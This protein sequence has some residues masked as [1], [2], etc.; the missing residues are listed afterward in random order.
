MVKTPETAPILLKIEV[1]PLVGSVKLIT[2]CNQAGIAYFILGMDSGANSSI[3]P[4]SELNITIDSI[5]NLS[6]NSPKTF[7]P[8]WKIK[9]YITVLSPNLEY[10][11]NVNP[12][13]AS[14]NYRFFYFNSYLKYF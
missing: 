14:S 1:R 5:K 8:F 9:G 7:D 12:I 3:N 11:L 4:K 13:Q 10:T 6:I 2:A